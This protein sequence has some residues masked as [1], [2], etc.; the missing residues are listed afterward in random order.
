V[1]DDGLRFDAGTVTADRIAE[2]ANYEGIRVKFVGYLENARI[3]IQIDL[4]LEM[5]LRL[6]R[7]RPNC[8]LSLIFLR[9]NC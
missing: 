2:D 7:S 4:G 1:E 6:R 8:Q 5:Q 9:Q 3:P